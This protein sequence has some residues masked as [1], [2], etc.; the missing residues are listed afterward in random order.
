MEHCL[1]VEKYRPHRVVDCILPD[2][3]KR[4]FQEIVDKG[5]MPNMI[6]CGKAGTGKTTAA[7]AMCDELELSRILVNASENGNI[8]TLRTTIKEFAST[9]S[10][11]GDRKVVILD[12]ADYLNPNSTQPA[13]RGAIEEYAANVSF[14]F[15]C[16]RPSRIIPELHSR[17][18]VIEYTI[19]A[20]EKPVMAKQFMKRLKLILDTEGVDYEEKVLA[21]LIM[22]HFPD[23]RRIINEL[24]RYAMNGKIDAGILAQVRDVPMSELVKA[25]SA[26]DFAAVRKWCAVHANSDSVKIMRKLYDVLYEHFEPK[27]IPELCL[28]LGRYQYQ[29]AFAQDQEINLVACLTEIMMNSEIKK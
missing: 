26:D 27:C 28:I 19:P 5:L 25:I 29:A 24:Q 7:L 20:A 9:R 18:S 22:K 6:L 3:I 21:E 14:I 1:W 15:T 4:T 8:D 11:T 17:A 2:N 16:N 13:L 23:F 10:F 12:E